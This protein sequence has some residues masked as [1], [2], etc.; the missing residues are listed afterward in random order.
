[1]TDS[2]IEVTVRRLKRGIL[3]AEWV[4]SSG[5]LFAPGRTAEEALRCIALLLERARERAGENP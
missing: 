1:M 4:A 3:D 2:T 5:N